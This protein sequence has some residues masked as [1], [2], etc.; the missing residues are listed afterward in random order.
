MTRC[1]CTEAI[2]AAKQARGLSWQQI[3]DAIGRH[4]VWA[5][6]ALLGQASMDEAEATKATELLG[7]G[8]EVVQALRL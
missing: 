4:V 1:E 6:A 8:P 5:T 2:L 7:L 3:A